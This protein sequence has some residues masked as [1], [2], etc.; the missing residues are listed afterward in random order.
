VSIDYSQSGETITLSMPD[1]KVT[2]II[3]KAEDDTAVIDASKISG[4]I[5]AQMPKSA[6]T[7]LAQAGLDVEIRLPHGTITLDKNAAKAVA[8]QVIG[9]SIAISVEEISQTSLTA[10]QKAAIGPNDKVFKITILS[11][12]Q[13]I[14]S[15]D[16]NITVAVPYDGELPVAVWYLD[17]QGNLEK[18]PCVYDAAAKI[19]TFT[20]D[21]LSL[22]V[23]GRERSK[24]PDQ[25]WENPFADIKQSDWFY[26]AVEYVCSN[27]LMVGTSTK[28]MLFSPHMTL[29]R[30]M[31]V[32]VLYRLYGNP[33]IST[34]PNPFD[35]V[36]EG[37]W[38]TDAIR[39]AAANGIVSGYGNG[40]FGPDDNI[41]REQLAVMIINYQDFSGS[42]PSDVFTEREFADDND[43]SD[44]AKAAVKKLT[45]QGIIS[46][47]LGNLFDPKG[48]ATRAEFAVILHRFSEAVK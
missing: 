35:D 32:T 36:D 48:E 25:E 43:I 37:K 18:V 21:H 17:D 33:D 30:G 23:V 46:G 22:Y 27:N 34:L 20:T 4:I 1:S 42:I 38:Y 44:W 26:K 14:H 12:T 29:T 3:N 8:A 11:G 31:V 28:P 16:G 40:K 45:M 10:E 7:K 19:V 13:E 6:L 41:T 2:E 39:W 24:L 15:Y 47:K 5:E 9:T